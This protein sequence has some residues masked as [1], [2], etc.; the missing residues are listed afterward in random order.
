[1]KL[2]QFRDV[3][4]DGVPFADA[5]AKAQSRY[6]EAAMAPQ[7]PEAAKK[8][9]GALTPAEKHVAGYAADGGPRWTI[10]EGLTVDL[11]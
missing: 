3:T 5:G 10:P 1:M 7:R 6:I 2:P 4:I 11:S 8:D 9:P